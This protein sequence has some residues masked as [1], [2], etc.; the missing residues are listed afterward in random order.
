M[1]GRPTSGGDWSAWTNALNTWP[2]GVQGPGCTSLGPNRHGPGA[3]SWMNS[4]TSWPNWTAGSKPGA[5]SMGLAI[6]VSPLVSMIVFA[7][8]ELAPWGPGRL[9]GNE[10]RLGQKRTPLLCNRGRLTGDLG[11]PR[12]APSGRGGGRI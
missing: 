10:P 7:P 5:V 4:A 6:L 3:T 8:M 9:G 1:P 12:G 2:G 11:T